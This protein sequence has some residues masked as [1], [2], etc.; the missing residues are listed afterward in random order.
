MIRRPPRSTLFPYTTL[1]RSR[2][3]SPFD[4]PRLR[5]CQ[6][7]QFFDE[8]RNLFVSLDPTYNASSAKVVVNAVRPATGSMVV[9]FI[10]PN[11][12]YKQTPTGNWPYTLVLS[13]MAG[14]QTTLTVFTV[15]GANNLGAFG[16]GTIV[17]PAKGS[18]EALLAGNNLTV[19]LNR[20]FHFE[21]KDL[22]G[23]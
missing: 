19:P 23:T 12:V 17:I 9:P 4:N 10:T 7:F 2:R 20:V 1:F 6:S 18:L 16:T 13:E 5:R 3:L 14:V 8:R 11:P 15:N 22:D 21:G